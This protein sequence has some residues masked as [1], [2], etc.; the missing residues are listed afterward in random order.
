M[1]NFRSSISAGALAAAT[2]A[3]G[4]AAAAEWFPVDVLV[5]TGGAVEVSTYTPIDR[6]SEAWG[7][8][9]ALPHL[10][11][12]Y[13]LAVSYGLAEEA[14]RL[15]V[16]LTVNEAGGYT[17]LAKQISQI[18][19]CAVTGADAVLI[20][21][22][23]GSGLDSLIAELDRQGIVVIDFMNGV[24]SEKVKGRSLV[25]FET[26][27]EYI[28]KYLAEAHPS[29]SGEVEVAWFPGPAGASWVEAGNTGFVTALEG[30]DVRLVDTRYGDTGKE[31]QLKLVEDTLQ[32]FAELDYIVGTAPTAEAAA[33]VLK[34]RGMSDQI[35]ILS[36][37]ITPG[38][39]DLMSEGVIA[40]APTDS[41]VLQ[42][43]IAVALAVG[44][45]EGDNEMHHLGPV[46]MVVTVDG[47]ADFDPQTT[48]AP[49]DY[50][51]VFKVTQ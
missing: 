26:M 20:G 11:D 30:S 14:E 49:A 25:S 33:Q 17:N 45:L 12:P 31:V 38:I 23:S 2:L 36:Y 37:Y 35:D 18:E 28:G 13:W 7:I 39:L 40:A 47:L 8:C 9:A 5:N 27:G 48:V 3:A 19:D 46:P 10:K 32:S 22:I 51:P 50:S 15:G 34:A 1:N 16:N 43:R 44:A 41:T 4:P 6:A 24:S 42:A 29:G 21:A